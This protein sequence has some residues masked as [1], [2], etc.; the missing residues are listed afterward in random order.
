MNFKNKSIK[1]IVYLSKWGLIGTLIGVAGGLIGT[2]FHISVE[3]VTRLRENNFGIIFLL[4]FGG[5]LICAMYNFFSSK[6][7]IDT[8]RVFQ[9][10]R[11]DKDV[12]IV[13]MPLI[14]I[15]AVITHMLGGSAG[16]EGAA[17]QLGGSMGYNA[18]QVLKQDK[19]SIK[20]M[21]TSGMSSVFSA[22]FGTPLA[23]T[24]FSLE[25]TKN[26]GFNFKG[27]LPGMI[28]SFVAFTVSNFL[29]V[30]PVRLDM[31]QTTGF[32]AVIVLKVVVLAILCA[33]ICIV[34]STSI[35]KTEFL[36]EKYVANVY[37]R[38][39]VGGI[40][41]VI[42]TLLA[43][44]TDYNGVGMHVIKRAVLGEVRYE[45]FALKIVFTAITVAAG[46]KGGEIVPTFFIGAT[47]GGL[48]SK[49]IGIN[50]GFGASLGLAA[51]FSGMTKCPVAAFLLAL[52]VFGVNSIP[53]FII[54]VII[55][56]VLSG[57]FGLYEE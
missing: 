4:P 30:N 26:K 56:R 36:M 19:Q 6:G 45:A 29:G 55:A 8:K 10:V 48:A 12:P 42:L 7:N 16:R 38:A 49:L 21:V 5:L 11:E 3:Y 54:V 33:G 51:M 1:N 15:G 28:S 31:P 43:G 13:M 37:L 57:R 32:D 52:E 25:V 22:L 34:F 47:F 20:I 40:L 23:A 41:I 35:K 14:F 27:L 24:V 46:F 44:T 53:F 50:Q 18:G 2:A 17:L 39:V 9:S